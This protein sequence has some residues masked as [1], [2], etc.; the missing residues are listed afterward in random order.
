MRELILRNGTMVVVVGA[1]ALVV[2]LVAATKLGH[3]FGRARFL[4]GD[5][6]E[7]TFGNISAAVFALLGLLMAFALSGATGRLDTRR[8][9]IV[10][11]ANAIGTAWLRLDL[12]PREAQS[13][14]RA[15]LRRYADARAHQHALIT[16]PEEWQRA[17]AA[18]VAMQDTIWAQAV[19]ATNTP[20]G[21]P[22]RILVLPALNE[23][24]DISTTRT[25]SVLTH[26][27]SL[28]L[29]AMIVLAFVC[30]W[31]AG[32]DSGGKGRMSP[33]HLYGFELVIAMTFFVII[34]LEYPSIGF[35]RMGSANDA[36]VET[37][38]HM[39]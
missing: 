10:Q 24:I 32:Y 5:E 27:P 22:T 30:A 2:S 25:V 3:R 8:Q 35:V 37:A 13:S 9:V 33:T 36:L 1:V 11:E 14:L 4:A 19:A 29:C 12:L 28:I 20:E 38:A 31:L 39:R 23:M 15:L 26:L 16:R 7:A 17:I 6:E 21:I 18:S 34:D